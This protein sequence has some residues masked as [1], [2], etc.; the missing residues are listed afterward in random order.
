MAKFFKV[1]GEVI[2]NND[3]DKIIDK[4]DGKT[5]EM[6]NSQLDIA[7]TAIMGCMQDC[8]SPIEMMLALAMKY[9]NL[10]DAGRYVGADV[11]DVSN[12]YE[13]VIGKT[14]KT[15]YRVDFMIP[16]YFPKYGF[17]KSYVIECNGHEFHE[18]TKDQVAK[19]NK[20]QRD[21]TR[22]GY[23]VINFSGSEIYNDATD[24]A[25]QIKKIIT[26]QAK[27]VAIQHGEQG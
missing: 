12:Q 10:L 26:T 18:K 24:C 15:T 16:V 21:L 17:G 5:F 27:E 20:R 14:S 3:L 4:L 19:D 11:V 25:M 8:E 13:I 6:V 7:K 23:T 1:T 9:A 2:E 22:E